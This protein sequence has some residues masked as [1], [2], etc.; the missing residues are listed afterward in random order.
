MRLHSLSISNFRKLKQ[1]TIN[2]R[3]TTF[4]IGPNNAGKS[5]VFAALQQLHKN[6][7]LSREDFS[8]SYCE[9][10]GDYQ[11]AD[12]VTLVA[13]YHNLPEQAND[14][15]GFRGRVIRHEDILA[16]ETPYKII[17]K[18]QWSINTAKPKIFMLEYNRTVSAAYAD[19]ATVS[20]LVGEDFTEAFIKEFFGAVNF[21]KALTLKAVKEKLID[22]PQYWHIDEDAAA[23]WVENP[24][25]I[26]GNVISLSLIHI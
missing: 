23:D 3:D 5:S 19:C 4:L 24:G 11:Y 20:D 2:F 12:N 8:K 26:P 21:D 14:W 15:L 7:A 16:G 9:E 18:K 6:T 22:L 13:E 1:C 25:G 10:E 17:Y